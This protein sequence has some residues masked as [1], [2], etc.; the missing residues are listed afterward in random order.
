MQETGKN[1]G[2]LQNTEETFI[3][4]GLNNPTVQQVLKNVIS[5]KLKR[6]IIPKPR[7]DN[8]Y[9]EPYY[10]VCV[11]EFKSN[12]IS[13]KTFNENIFCKIHFDKELSFG[14]DNRTYMYYK[15]D[16]D[17]YTMFYPS[18]VVVEITLKLL[19]SVGKSAAESFNEDIS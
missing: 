3:S 2:K 17:D 5:I 19:S 11:D 8:Y 1:T 12:I 4:S 6:V 15:N 14:N 9:P 13:T 10:F 16:D 18:Q 7:L